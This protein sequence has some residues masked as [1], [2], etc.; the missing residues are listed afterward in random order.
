[1]HSLPRDAEPVGKARGGTDAFWDYS[2][3][4]AVRESERTGWS[5]V[6][7][8]YGRAGRVGEVGKAYIECGA[9]ATRG[10]CLA[11]RP[12]WRGVSGGR[13]RAS[14]AENLACILG[15]RFKTRA[16]RPGLKRKKGVGAASRWWGV[17]RVHRRFSTS[18]R[19]QEQVG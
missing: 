11:T 5:G 15:A 18:P 14:P 6:G 3:A 1:M 4:V 12:R 17:C 16:S 8:G 7:R 13:V 19:P 2:S 10:R 9:L